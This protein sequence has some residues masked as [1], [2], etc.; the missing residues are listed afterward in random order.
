MAF[1]EQLQ[2]LDA[3]VN[4]LDGEPVSLDAALALFQE[5]IDLLRQASQELADAESRVQLL[6]EQAENVFETPDFER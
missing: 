6:V 2:R 3:I 4:E 1:E 5:G